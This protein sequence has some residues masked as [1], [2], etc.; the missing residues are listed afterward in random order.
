[1]LEDVLFTSF[2]K[3]CKDEWEGPPSISV[4]AIGGP[5]ICCMRGGCEGSSRFLT[6]LVFTISPLNVQ[7]FLPVMHIVLE[8]YIT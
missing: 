5:I 3:F 2:I 6:L 1:M 4:R 7:S 8:M